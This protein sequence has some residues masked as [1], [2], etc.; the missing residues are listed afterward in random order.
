MAACYSWIECLLAVVC[1]RVGEY[2]GLER[3]SLA[4]IF[5]VSCV[6]HWLCG[7]HMVMY[8]FEAV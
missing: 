3:H 8:A 2:L 7:W 1:S 4:Y 6:C 5:G